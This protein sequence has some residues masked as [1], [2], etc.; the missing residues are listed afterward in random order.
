[1][2]SDCEFSTK[3]LFEQKANIEDGKFVYSRVHAVSYV[4]PGALT[5]TTSRARTTIV[6]AL[7]GY[8]VITYG[9]TIEKWSD[10]GWIIIEEFFDTRPIFKNENEAQDYLLALYKSFTLGLPIAYKNPSD[11]DEPKPKPVKK[12]KKD[13]N[14]KLRVL[15]FGK[16]LK[17][18]GIDNTYDNYE[19]KLKKDD[20]T[21]PKKDKDDDDDDSPDFDWI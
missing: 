16:H 15:S 4:Y 5:H 3:M 21:K 20:K 14:P 1:M 2:S 6:Y 13:K 7:E 10:K 19:S 18:Q 11:D 8:E 17:D 9:G 12:A